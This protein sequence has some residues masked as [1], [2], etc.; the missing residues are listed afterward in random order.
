MARSGG[1]GI[2][3][4][5]AVMNRPDHE[6]VTRLF[7]EARALPEDDRTAFLESHCA[8]QPA[9]RREVEELLAV[10]DP[11]RAAFEAVD[12]QTIPPDPHRVGPY[13]L[14]EPVGEGG[15][16]VVYRAQQHAPIRRTVAIKLIKLGM[17]TRKFVARFEAERQALAMMQ[18]PNI[19]K[20]YDAGAT[21]TG[22]PFFAMEFVDGQRILR[23]CDQ[24]RLTL[25]QRLELFIPVCDA[26]EHAHRRGIIHRDLK[27]SNVL[28]SE[29]DGR[30]APKVID[31]GVA[32]VVAGPTSE[33]ATLTEPSQLVGTPAYM[34]PEQA[35]GGALH[36]DTR[37][38]IYSLGVLLYQLLSGV[39]PISS[40]SLRSG[41][42]EELR[43]II[44]Q[45]DPPRPAARVAALSE[46][47][48]EVVSR[49]RGASPTQLI[50]QLRN[51]LEWI[52]LKAMRKDR[53]QRYRS[54]AELGD[55]LRNYL[56]GRPL[57]AGPES[58][59]Y[60]LRKF[61]TRHRAGVIAA[62]VVGLVLVAG[63]IA[64]ALQTVRA[65]RAEA[66][67][68]AAEAQALLERDNARATLEFFTDE[69]LSNATPDNIPDAKV[70]DQIVRALIAPAAE[71]VGESFRDRPVIEASVRAAVQ[72]VFRDIGRAELALPH[73][74]T[75]LAIRRRELGDD[76]PDTMQSMNDLGR[77]LRMLG[78]FA[79]AEPVYREALDRRR[80]VL[81]E[82]HAD[83]LSSL[84]NYAGILERRGRFAEA[85]PLYQRA[86][87]LRRRTLG[88][89]HSST[90]LSLNNYA[91]ILYAQGQIAEAEPL[92]RD[93][94]D[95]RRR[96]NGD[97]HPMTLLAI[98]NHADA[99]TQLERFAEA[100]PM[101]TEALERYR[102]VM[103]PADPRTLTAVSNYAFFLGR[104]GRD[105]EAMALHRDVWDARRRSLGE[106]HPETLF[107]MSQYATS[108]G[109]AGRA[110][111]GEPIARMAL[112]TNQRLFGDDHPNTLMAANQH[113]SLLAL[114]G[115]VVEA[116]A[117]FADTARRAARVRSPSD[118]LAIVAAVQQ[119]ETLLK[120]HRPADAERLV[121]PILD[122]AVASASLGPDSRPAK[123]GAKVLA[124]CLDALN[125]P[126]DAA[127]V[128]QR[129]GLADPA[130]SPSST[131]A[132][133][134]A[135]ST[136]PG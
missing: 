46:E 91:H 1:F 12:A 114:L 90:I 22:R 135:P 88:E 125:R 87:E 74:E 4:R 44:T 115:R 55:D 13:E 30:A 18:H 43:R 5:N 95:R 71:R 75:A 109:L 14:L 69:V 84:N 66:A 108:L 42:Y 92:Y 76:H 3:L 37:S 25:R 110:D 31:F 16:A 56:A 106:E 122:L 36:V 86:L 78:R 81:G 73:S 96:L 54:A 82:A 15:M 19:A 20:V 127:T 68:R 33:L 129:F 103:G 99:L 48:A 65:R 53:E 93:A 107:S 94:L 10:D 98:N 83:T 51:E 102:R 111:E 52:P 63:V 50:R 34:S 117:L 45:T 17:D 58:R 124:Q 80:R 23:W 85:Q 89:D 57:L 29:F 67:A 134:S 119:A 116:E 9:L 70:R 126:A 131:P 64:T 40:S 41:S 130:T 59:T 105:A 32:K 6:L 21:S 77:V 49:R 24:R 136:R 120:L 27:D 128:R 79:D 100:E 28:V 2:C 123:R 113:A 101:Y 133:S 26:V 121:R 61:L 118:P 35:E 132:P 47:Q 39:E 97:D 62:A 8:D 112:A 72:T 7:A 11:A 38:D 60:L 104:V